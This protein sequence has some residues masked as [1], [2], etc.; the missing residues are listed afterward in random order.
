MEGARTLANGERQRRHAAHRGRDQLSSSNTFQQAG[1]RIAGDS[2]PDVNVLT[3]P[4]RKTANTKSMLKASSWP[5][6]DASSNLRNSA[7]A[8]RREA[9]R[10]PTAEI[11]MGRRDPMLNDLLQTAKNILARGPD[12]PALQKYPKA[13]QTE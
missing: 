4:T 12:H 9:G 5:S 2:P 10:R 1:E 6:M 8:R 7:F 13:A 3:R 11:G